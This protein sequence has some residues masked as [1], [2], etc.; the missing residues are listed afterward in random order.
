MSTDRN[1]SAKREKNS[2]PQTRWLWV[3]ELF[4]FSFVIFPALRCVVSFIVNKHCYTATSNN[5]VRALAQ[6]DRCFSLSFSVRGKSCTF[7][8]SGGRAALN[9][10]LQVTFS[11]DCSIWL[12]FKFLWLSQSCFTNCC[13]NVQVAGKWAAKKWLRADKTRCVPRRDWFF[14]KTKSEELDQCW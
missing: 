12:L 13:G 4:C 14:A 3:R 9:F 11:T 6:L 7:R 2:K 5:S 1:T 8:S 10:P